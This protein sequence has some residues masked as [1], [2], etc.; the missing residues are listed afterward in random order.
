[1]ISTSENHHHWLLT[2][3]YLGTNYCGWQ[4]QK[5]GNAVAEELEKVLQRIHG[6]RVVVHGASRTD[7]GVHA[8][9]QRARV[10]LPK[11]MGGK[12]LLRAFN[13]LLPPDIRVMALAPCAADFNPRI[14]ARLKTYR[15][16]LVNGPVLSPFLAATHHWVRRPLHLA[17]M[18]EAA[19]CFL[20]RHDF[21][22]FRAAAGRAQPPRRTITLSEWTIPAQGLLHYR[23]AGPGFMH[24]QV[25]IMA[26]TLLEVGMGKR[27]AASVAALLEGG[28]RAAAGVTAVPQGLVL[29]AIEYPGESGFADGIISPPHAV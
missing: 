15:Y 22:A 2:V 9:G 14:R 27:T 25:R 7:A 26:G 13:T 20:G 6:R 17:Q 18:R 28:K 5:N 24:Q 29:E 1:V 19:A 21:S 4:R 23:V 8:E 3:A 12:E 16:Q 11:A 10:S